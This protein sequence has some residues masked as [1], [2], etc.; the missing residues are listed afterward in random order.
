MHFWLYNI[1]FI[2]TT[3]TFS[4]ILT[5]EIMATESAAAQSDAGHRYYF[6]PYRLSTSSKQL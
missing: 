5:T 3:I 1:L 4:Y 2:I 6:G